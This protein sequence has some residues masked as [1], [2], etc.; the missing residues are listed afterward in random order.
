[1]LKQL[2]SDEANQ[3]QWLQEVRKRADMATEGPWEAHIPI[4]N[5]NEC[6][7]FTQATLK[8][9]IPFYTPKTDVQ[10]KRDCLF[11]AHART[12]IPRLLTL[13]EELQAC[14]NWHQ[15]YARNPKTQQGEPIEWLFNELS[16]RSAKIK[17]LEAENA[18]LWGAL[19][20][21][22][23]NDK[24]HFIDPADLGTPGGQG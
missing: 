8:R 23:K 11:L 1:M 13:V 5:N 24:T 14:I 15:I 21:V 4:T 6:Y 2:T 7:G 22:I 16:E 3:E 19:E 9:E 17:A 12:D 20:A 10:A 18:R